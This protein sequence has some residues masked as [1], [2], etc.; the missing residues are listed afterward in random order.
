MS[1]EVPE[2]KVPEQAKPPSIDSSSS[3]PAASP[4]EVPKLVVAPRHLIVLIHGINGTL[5]FL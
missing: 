4:T 2:I 5:L 1:I 3:S